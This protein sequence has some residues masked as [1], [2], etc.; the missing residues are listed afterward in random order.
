LSI[1]MDFDYLKR[2][3][4]NSNYF[5]SLNCLTNQILYIAKQLKKSYAA[6][7]CGKII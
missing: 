4:F 6:F 7:R 1:Y 5:S 3:M 2:I